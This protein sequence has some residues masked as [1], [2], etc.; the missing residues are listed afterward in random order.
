MAYMQVPKRSPRLEYRLQQREEIEASPL[1]AE[2]FPGLKAMTVR[3]E[4]FDS[5][6]TSKQGE[7][8][9]RLNIERAR[10]AVWFD[11]PGLECVGG[12]FDLSRAVAAAVAAGQKAVTGELRCHGIRHRGNLESAVCRSILRYQLILNYD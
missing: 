5:A 7:M 11:C 4:F 9:W 3:L 12:D 2:K 1:L 10:S 6:A 8:E